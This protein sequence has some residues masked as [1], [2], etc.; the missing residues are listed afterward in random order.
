MTTQREKIHSRNK[1]ARSIALATELKRAQSILESYVSGK[2]SLAERL[3]GLH[4]RLLQE[5][6]HLAVLG[7]FKRGKST[8]I[9]AILGAPV[10]PTAV[11]PLTAVAIFIAWGPEPVARVLFNG[12]RTPET[13][14]SDDAQSIRHFLSQ[15]VAEEQNPQNRLRVRRAE[16]Y[17]PAPILGNGTVL[18]DTPGVGSTFQHNT[19]AAIQVLP[20]CDAALFVVS[21]D[22]PITEI[23]LAYLQRLKAKAM[24]LFFILNKLDYLEPHEQQVAIEF[25]RKILSER[26][27]LDRS[28]PIFGVSARNGLVAKQR[29][30]PDELERS[31]IAAVE[32]HLLHYLATEKLESLENAIRNKTADILLQARADAELRIRTLSI[33]IEELAFKAR[34]FED[35]LHSIEEQQLTM[36]DLLA[37]NKRRL[38]GEIE[39]RIYELR[40]EAA[41]KLGAALDAGLSSG[42]LNAAEQ[43]AQSAASGAI[44]D[45]FEAARERLTGTFAREAAKA[46]AA[47]QQRLDGLVD[48]VRRTAAELFDVSFGPQHEQ[49]SFELGE[50]PYWVTERI[51]ATLIPDPGRIVDQLVPS[52]T[53]RSRL[54]ARIMKQTND[55]IVRNAE[56]LRWAIL[57]GIEDTIRKAAGRLEERLDQAVAATKGVI[58]DALARR[59]DR[60]LTIDTEVS[61]LARTVADLGAIR[62]NL[63]RDLAN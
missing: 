50:D 17:Y 62:E 59:Q 29:N 13:I 34:S 20:E 25:L 31:G 36:S 22:P 27:L 48:S 58:E 60:S 52:T 38:L 40:D 43:T 7:Q 47:H 41:S 10:L 37:G 16:L 28:A 63:V 30:D 24:R 56:N 57:Q 49:D 19:E 2:S 21:V 5:R 42:S 35:A 8:F 23:E 14:R 46:L 44:Q 12:D 9:N 3:A 11:V 32:D 61:T 26:L 55:L 6:L 33:P 54:R 51:N 4:S 1:A 53:R 45:F 15:F 18:I 39:D